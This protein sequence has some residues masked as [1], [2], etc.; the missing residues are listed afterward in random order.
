MAPTIAAVHGKARAF[1]EGLTRLPRSARAAAPHGHF[2][3]D[4]NTLRKLALEVAPDLDERLLGKYIAVY[5]T[6]GGEFS[7]ASYVEIEVYARQIVGQLAL[8]LSLPAAW[9]AAAVPPPRSAAVPTKAYDVA[10][11]RQEYSQAYAPWSEEDDEYLRSR[12]L[13]GA[14]VEE[15]VSEFGRR[16]GGIR[17]RLRK[18]G[19]E[20]LCG[21]SDAAAQGSP[22]EQAAGAELPEDGSTPPVHEWK[23]LRPQAGRPWSPEEDEAL[24]RDFEA[25]FS[26]EEIAQVRGRGVFG[27]EVRLSK[28][29]RDVNVRGEGPAEPGAAAGRPRDGGSPSS[30]APSA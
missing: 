1:V 23:R 24:L 19:L 6:P 10:V 15:L 30:T 21:L 28:L 3:R 18:L 5:E 7:H 17:S 8:L 25:G 27:V 2:A 12:F 14:T 4:Y 22:A 11:I 9:A 20:P 13:E 26:L 29:G 16:P